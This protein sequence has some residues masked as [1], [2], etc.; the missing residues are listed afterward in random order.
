MGGVG[1]G[2]VAG[3]RRG[4]S[5]AVEEGSVHGVARLPAVLVWYMRVEKVHPSV[6]GFGFG[7]GEIGSAREI[8]VVSTRGCMCSRRLILVV[9]RV[10]V[11]MDGRRSRICG[12]RG[13]CVRGRTHLCDRGRGL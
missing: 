8:L 5:F 2:L 7:I 1:V 4:R 13:N 12:R 11:S 10:R 3:M 9:A 6:F